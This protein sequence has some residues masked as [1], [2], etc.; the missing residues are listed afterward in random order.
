MYFILYVIA[1]TTCLNLFN[2]SMPNIYNNT[3]IILLKLLHLLLLN[4]NMNKYNKSLIAADNQY[5]TNIL[6]NASLQ[7]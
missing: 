6:D 1:K 3:I 4:N 7:Y 2:V 5:G